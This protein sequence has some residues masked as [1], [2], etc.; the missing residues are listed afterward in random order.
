[1]IHGR[2]SA[3]FEM[4]GIGNR[5]SIGGVERH[6][7][8]KGALHSKEPAQMIL[9]DPSVPTYKAF[10]PACGNPISGDPDLGEDI[11]NYPAGHAQDERGSGS[12]I[13]KDLLHHR[14]IGGMPNDP[15]FEV[16]PELKETKGEI[17][18]CKTK[19]FCFCPMDLPSLDIKISDSYPA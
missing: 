19:P 7:G 8:R 4:K 6:R 9:L 1:M 17:L 10:D 2:G 16:P 14:K 13:H 3:E 18:P 15:L 5:Q 11:Q 12:F